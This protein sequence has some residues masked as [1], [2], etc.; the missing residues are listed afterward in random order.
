[1]LYTSL[2]MIIF[3]MC[4][5]LMELPLC[6]LGYCPF[7]VSYQH[8]FAFASSLEYY[9]DPPLVFQ[10][11]QIPYKDHMEIEHYGMSI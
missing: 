6:M 1:M 8:V 11:R 10:Q 5:K 2:G 7:D 3:L 9:L 4:C